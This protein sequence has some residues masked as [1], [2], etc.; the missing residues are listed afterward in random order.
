MATNVPFQFEVRSFYAFTS[1]YLAARSGLYHNT[2]DT[3]EKESTTLHGELEIQSD[4]TPLCFEGG[5]VEDAFI[6]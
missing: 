6:S 1:A 4:A 3:T 5:L 2:H